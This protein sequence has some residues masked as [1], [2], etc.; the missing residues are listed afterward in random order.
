MA[1]VLIFLVHQVDMP[2][3]LVHLKQMTG[4]VS[5]LD[6]RVHYS[7]QE[8]QDQLA[9]LGSKGRDFY[10]RRILAELDLVLPVIFA[11][12]LTVAMATAFRGLV[13]EGSRWRFLQW[14]P[15]AA[16]VLDFT[17]NALI[18]ALLL[19]YPTTHPALAALAGWTTTAKLLAY[20][21]SVVTCLVAGAARSP[22]GS[23]RR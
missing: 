6:E 23:L 9:A 8:A 4:G 20:L 13:A 7:A 15:V 1:A 21:A 22:T 5:I 11:L 10:L 17:E 12:V 19:D 16:M 14:L 2:W 18:A 3:S